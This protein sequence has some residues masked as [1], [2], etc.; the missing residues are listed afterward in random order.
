MTSSAT[1]S[2][3]SKI[4]LPKLSR[5]NVLFRADP[6]VS[7]QRNE[8]FLLA[9]FAT[10][11]VVMLNHNR[12]PHNTDAPAVVAD[13]CGHVGTPGLKGFRQKP[14][15]SADRKGACL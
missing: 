10:W 8:D 11:R 6:S 3:L 13:I 4:K 5:R 1:R 12:R 9:D 2:G 7:K 15:H 14:R